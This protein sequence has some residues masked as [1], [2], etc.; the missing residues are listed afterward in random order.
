VDDA[1]DC[2]RRTVLAGPLQ[3]HFELLQA[4]VAFRGKCFQDFV[5]LMQGG[6]S[7]GLHTAGAGPVSPQ[8]ATVRGAGR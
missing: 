8:R 5:E 1:E 2:A 4:F 3:L 6:G 7:C